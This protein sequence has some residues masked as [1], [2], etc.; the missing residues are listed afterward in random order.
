MRAG[1][2]RRRSRK[3]LT[4]PSYFSLEEHLSRFDTFIE[5]RRRIERPSPA[6]L[7]RIARRSMSCQSRGSAAVP[8]VRVLTLAT[9]FSL[10]TWRERRRPLRGRSA[11]ARFT[12]PLLNAPRLGQRGRGLSLALQKMLTSRR[13]EVHSLNLPRDD[14]ALAQFASSFSGL[15][16]GRRLISSA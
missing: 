4:S 7:A 14:F 5:R 11:S 9:E 3:P 12:L 13:R 15:P 2:S 16:R 8:A 1:C 6:I 10:R